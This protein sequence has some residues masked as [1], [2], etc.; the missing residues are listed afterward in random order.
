[1][2]DE[3]LK[4]ELFALEVEGSTVRIERTRPFVPRGGVRYWCAFVVATVLW[5]FWPLLMPPTTGGQVLGFAIGALLGSLPFGLAFVCFDPELHRGRRRMRTDIAFHLGEEAEGYRTI[6]GVSV[7]MDGTDLPAAADARL[8]YIVWRKANDRGTRFWISELSLVA[9]GRVFVIAFEGGSLGVTTEF[10]KLSEAG[11]VDEFGEPIDAKSSLSQP[12]RSTSVRSVRQL[13]DLLTVTMSKRIPLHRGDR[14]GQRLPQN[15]RNDPV[16]MILWI[17]P[18][19]WCWLLMTFSVGPRWWAAV[20]LTVSVILI[21]PAQVFVEIARIASHARTTLR[22][23]YGEVEPFPG[24]T[25]WRPKQ[26]LLL[27]LALPVILGLGWARLFPEL[28]FVSRSHAAAPAPV[29]PQ[30]P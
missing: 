16:L 7:T 2:A 8:E 11:L 17:F 27:A 12:G 18:I 15:F 10:V 19:L 22:Q 4:P 30:Q 1:L 14:N 23:V 5:G 21:F 3:R 28:T 13:A 20:Y 24:G 26:A 9:G 6:S 29:V 25:R